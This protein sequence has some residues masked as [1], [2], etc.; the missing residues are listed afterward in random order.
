[1]RRFEF[2]DGKSNKFWEIDLEGDSFTVRY[3]RIGT[4][5]QSSTKT[6]RSPEEAS[7]QADKLIASK[8]K[9]GYAEVEA[10]AAAAPKSGNPELERAIH[11]NPD[12]L[13]AW[14][15]YGDW[16]QEQGDPR[17]EL[18]SLEVLA[19]RGQDNDASAKRREQLFATHRDAWVGPVLAKALTVDNDEA[20]I[21]A[22][23]KFGF[24]HSVRMASHWDAEG[25]TVPEMLRAMLK[26]ESAKFLH[27][28]AFGV[29]D[30]EGDTDFDEV[31]LPLSKVGK[32]PSLRHLTVGDYDYEDQ[33][34]TWVVVG[35]V[36]RLWP[37]LPNLEYLK[38][39][40]SAVEL[41]TVEHPK[42]QQLVIETAGLTKDA[43]RSLS[44]AKLPALT[45]LEAWIGEDYRSEEHGEHSEIEDFR[46]LLAGEATPALTHLGLK[47]ADFEDDIAVALCTAP[48]VKQLRTLDLSMGTMA[49]VGARALVENAAH[50]KHLDRIDLDENAIDDPE[51]QALTA[52][53]GERVNIGDQEPS[54][55]PE[56]RYVS[57]SE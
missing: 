21:E 20:T 48:I 51:V 46:P 38:V 42:L 54:D 7:K 29:T 15:V 30:L 31:M 3:G 53:F 2:S 5:G 43:A 12:D 55:D 24:L 25:P 33:E 45:S 27:K 1:M 9:K 13:D 49:E 35:N 37:V 23:W 4:D 41:G 22:E 10:T 40:G 11:D 56:D 32:L 18:V 52:A 57:V 16:L 39:R 14:A 47:N 19:A 36:G 28:L 8:T 17:G 6:Y 34:I 50:F 26:V 44:A